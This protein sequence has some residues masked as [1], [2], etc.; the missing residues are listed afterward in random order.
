MT[1]RVVFERLFGV[2]MVGGVET[3]HDVMGHRTVQ[4]VSPIAGWNPAF[5]PYNTAQS[6]NALDF[7]MVSKDIFA[8]RTGC[9]IADTAFPT[10]DTAIAIHTSGGAP[11]STTKDTHARCG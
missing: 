8:H 10:D 4:P 7:V 9:V 6:D 11:R 2:T 3:I 5:R 1:K